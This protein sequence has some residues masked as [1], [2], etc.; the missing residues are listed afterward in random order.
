MERVTA[1]GTREQVGEARPVAG[2]GYSLSEFDLRGMIESGEQIRGLGTHSES[3]QAA[4]ELLVRYL[5][6]SFRSLDGESD[7]VLVRC[8]KTHRLRELPESLHAR[9]SAM[10]KSATPRPDIPCL[11]LLATAGDQPE[12]NDVAASSGHA[13]IPLESAEA[14]ES[15]PM[16]AHLMRELGIEFSAVLDP[17]PDLLLDA[18]QRAYGV[19][20]VEDAVGSISVP[21][22]D[23]VKQFGVR[24]VMGFGGLLPSGDLFAVILFSRVAISREVST[25]FRTLALSVK[26]VLLPFTR[27]P[28]FAGEPRLPMTAERSHEEEQLRSEA[29]TLRLLIRALEAAALDQT[30]RLQDTIAD[31][32]RQ[33]LQSEKLGARLSAMLESTTDAVFLLDR[34]WRFTYLNQHAMK[35]LQR[36]AGL[37]GKNIWD[38]FPE[39]VRGEYWRHYHAAMIDQTPARFE[40]HYPEPIDKW[41]EV[42]AFPSDPGIAVFFHDVT[43]RRKTEEVLLRNEKLAAV[44]RLAASIAHEINNPLESVTNLLYLARTS[45]DLEQVQDYLS[46]ADRELRRVGAITAQTLRFHKQATRPSQVTCAELIDG[47]LSIYQGRIVNSRVHVERKIETAKPVLCFDGEIRQVMNNLVGNAIDAMHP[48]GGLLLLRG[49]EAMDWKTGARGV[50]LTVADTGPGMNAQTL[51]KAMEPFFTTKGIGGAGL[52]L[53]ISKEIVERHSGRLLLR[54]VQDLRR[55][56]TVTSFFLPF[57]AVER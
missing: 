15:A 23:F 10:V 35:L 42:Y 20:H 34:E 55:H 24:S 12:W 50:C 31:L 53:W 3:M 39:A 4:A 5:R 21:G 19:F 38:E 41:F 16:I 8:F 40:E 32:S 9:A 49:R 37:L 1:P 51:A 48:D 17:S 11:T 29:A 22:Q 56:G 33:R 46:T 2:A 28:I 26:L 18:E 43:E 47:V 45:A 14:V 57:D 52:G 6:E 13:V 30:G 36:D 7:S 25:L 54:S 27:G 44:G